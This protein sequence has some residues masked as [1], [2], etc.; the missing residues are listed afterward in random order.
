MTAD[1]GIRVS[2]FTKHKLASRPPLGKARAMTPVSIDQTGGKASKT[3][4]LS[5]NLHF[6]LYLC[7]VK[8]NNNNLHVTTCISVTAASVLEEI[9]KTPGFPPF[10]THGILKT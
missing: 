1:K 6:T 9:K 4:V 5:Y 2:Q 3:P 10:R 8:E 7:S